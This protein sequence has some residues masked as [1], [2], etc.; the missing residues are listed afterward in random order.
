[1]RALLLITASSLALAACGE[2]KAADPAPMVEP[3]AAPAPSIAVGE[4]NPSTPAPMI[5]P[6][7]AVPALIAGTWVSIEDP[8]VSLTVTADGKWSEA[9]EGADAEGAAD[10]ASWRA[11]NGTEAKLA[12]PTDVFTPEATYL[13]VKG[14]D[15]MS[16]Y[17]LGDVDA[18]NLE[19][20]YVGRGNRLAYTRKK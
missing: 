11:I 16:Y 12:S 9:Y 17:E 5:V 2:Q 7:A 14:A 10:T 1:M 3:A 15:G 6:P 19:M 4:P 13:E 18:D 8:K 20:F